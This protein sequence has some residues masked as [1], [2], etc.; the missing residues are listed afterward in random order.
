[1]AGADGGRGSPDSTAV[2]EWKPT[3]RQDRAAQERR[4]SSEAAESAERGYAAR[5]KALGKPGFFEVYKRGQGRYTRWGTAIG[6]GVLIL[7]GANYAYEQ[8]VNLPWAD[9]PWFFYVQVA[10]PLAL[11]AGLGLLVFWL[12]GVNRRSCDFMIATEGE[13]KKVNW[14]SKREVVGSTKVV[15]V[16]VILLS[17]LL[18]AVDLTFILFFSAI[19][20]LKTNI[21]QRLFAP[22][23]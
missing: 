10:A 9:A 20:V 23:T 4:V 22:Q 17:V 2:S 8:M 6:A 19:G 16:S 12:V 11:I 1:M 21:L 15:I 3:G 14:T 13:M 5:P 18:F 7:A